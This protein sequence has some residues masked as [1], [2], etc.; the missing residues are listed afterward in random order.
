MYSFLLQKHKKVSW[1]CKTQSIDK[2][3][4]CLPWFENIRASFPLSADLAISLDCAHKSRLGSEVSCELINIDHHTTNEYFGDVNL[5]DKEA[6]S[7]T[8][9]LYDFFIDNDVKINKKMATALYAG[10]LDDSNS[11]TAQNVDGTTF[12]IVKELIDAGADFKSCNKSIL[13]TLSL[14]ALRL[15]AIMFKNL[16]LECEGRVAFFCVSYEDMLCSGAKPYDCEAP[17]EESLHLATVEVAVLLRENR[18]LCIKGSLRSKSSFKVDA[19]AALF[20]G[21]GHQN[22]AGFDLDNTLSQEEVKMKLLN[23]IKEGLVV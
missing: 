14:A 1:F 19:I 6:I 18:E 12:A 5:V 17:L 21:G 7:T 13:Q 16:S 10:I 4:S 3:F 9:V 2:K 23:C 22:R 15:K 20:G 8:K 11:F